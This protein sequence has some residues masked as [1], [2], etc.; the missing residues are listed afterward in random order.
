MSAIR[1]YYALLEVGE[2]ADPAEIKRAYHRL[3]RR[4]HPD[5]TGGDA[6]ASELFKSVHA[7][8]RV[9]T[10]PIKRHAYDKARGTSGSDHVTDGRGLDHM[11]FAALF[12][13]GETA[14]EPAERAAT[15]EL[16]LQVKLSFRQALVGGITTVRLPA[17][18]TIRIPVPRGT[19]HGQKIRIPGGEDVAASDL[20]IT[21]RV[22]P[23]ARFRREGDDLH[24]VETV[25]ALEAMLGTTR[26]LANAYGRIVRLPIPPGT[27]PG[28]RL[29]LKGQ[30]VETVS[31]R[32]DLYVE[33]Q[34]EVPRD[35]TEE[36]RAMLAR[37]AK[38]CGLL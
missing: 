31:E 35:L 17:G 6:A 22:E 15:R 11:S 3:A 28:D 30:G 8:Y 12:D 9:L 37:A 27:Q 2:G 23:D 32:G 1:D 34:V 4:L 25:T 13:L 33:V 18:D 19:R 7:A 36:Q 24:V 29:R 21:F 26:A 16:A 38:R 20:L 5:V 14:S 10:D